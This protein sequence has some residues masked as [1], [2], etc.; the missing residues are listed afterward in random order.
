MRHTKKRESVIR[1]WGIMKA[2][3]LFNEAGQMLDFADKNF[4]GIING[5]LSHVYG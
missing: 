1:M 4:K 5:S 2:Y 3:K